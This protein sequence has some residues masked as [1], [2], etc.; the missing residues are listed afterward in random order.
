MEYRNP[1]LNQPLSP[2]RCAVEFALSHEG[3][4]ITPGPRKPLPELRLH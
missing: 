2:E 1:R 4:P 3:R